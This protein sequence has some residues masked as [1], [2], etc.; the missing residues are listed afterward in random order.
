MDGSESSGPH[1]VDFM[2]AIGSDEK[3]LRRLNEIDNAETC[4]T[5]PA[6]KG[7]DAKWRIGMGEVLDVLWQFANVS[8]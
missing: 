8:N 4:S 2:L 1:D 3:L 6:S 7:T 5:S